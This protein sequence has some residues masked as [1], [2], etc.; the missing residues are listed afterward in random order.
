MVSLSASV[1]IRG[2]RPTARKK[3]IFQKCLYKRPVKISQQRTS[4]TGARYKNEYT[5]SVG[6]SATSEDNLID[7]YW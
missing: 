7:F 3:I 5:G 2:K 4:S 6:F 1:N